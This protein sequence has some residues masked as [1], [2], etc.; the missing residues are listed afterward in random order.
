MSNLSNIGFTVE[1][2]EEFEALAEKAYAKGKAVKAHGGTYIVYSD[3]SG[4]ELWFQLNDKNEFIGFNP[5]FRGKSRRSVYITAP[6]ERPHSALD[7]AFYA[8][9]NPADKDDPESGEFPFVFDLPDG[10]RRYLQDY[11][12]FSELQLAA[13]AQEIDYYESEEAY[14]NNQDSEPKWAVQSFVPTGLFGG[15][16]EDGEPAPAP[17][18]G[19][20]AG[21]VREVEKRT[22]KLTGDAFYWLLVDTLGGEVDVV[23]DLRYFE[24]EPIAGGVVFGYFW[25]SGQVVEEETERKGLFARWFGKN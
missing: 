24:V 25:L 16:E 1:T 10:K 23:A 13:F 3:P 17:A 18:Y 9:A 12:R 15:G 21:I 6:I 20:F 2:E 14:H 4:A 11:L 19:M 22:N 5:H 7:A 8:W